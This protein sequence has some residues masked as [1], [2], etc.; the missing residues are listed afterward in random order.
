MVVNR[1]ALMVQIKVVGEGVD[2]PLR[3]LIDAAPTMSPVFWRQRIGRIM[4]PVN[5]ELL[6]PACHSNREYG[7]PCPL[8]HDEGRVKEAPPE[9]IVT[10]HN[11]LRHGYLLKGVLPPKAFRDATTAWGPDFKP[12]RRVVARAAGLNGLGKF[13]PSQIPLSDGTF[14]WMF[15]LGAPDGSKQYAVLVNPA[16]GDPVCAVKKFVAADQNCT[17]PRRV[18]LSAA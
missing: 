18:H 3:R 15:V 1:K 17:R 16:G 14:W 9:Y 5:G 12:S 8:C 4:R 10:N 11:L 6:C 13:S 7:P 2:L